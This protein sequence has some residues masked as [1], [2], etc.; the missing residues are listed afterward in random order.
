MK[1]MV[2]ICSNYLAQNAEYNKDKGPAFKLLIQ[3][4]RSRSSVVLFEKDKLRKTYSKAANELEEAKGLDNDHDEPN[5]SQEIHANL[6]QLVENVTPNEL[7]TDMAET[8]DISSKY[9]SQRAIDELERGPAFDV[10]IQ[11]LEMRGA[12]PFTPQFTSLGVK[13]AAAY[14]LK[15]APGLSS[16]TPD[17]TT[18]PIFVAAL[19]RAADAGTPKTLRKD[20]HDVIER[21]GNYLSAFV[22]DRDKAMQII[23]KA[24]KSNPTKELTK[25]RR[26]ALDYGTAATETEAAPIVVPFLAIKDIATEGKDNLNKD[27]ETVTPVELKTAMKSAVQDVSRY[28]SQPVALRSGAAGARYPLNFLSAVTKSLGARPLFKFKSYGQTYS[29]A[30][31]VLKYAGPLESDPKCEQLQYEIM[32]EMKRGVPTKLAPTVASG[33]DEVSVDAAKHLAKIGTE[34]GKAMDY[35]VGVMKQKGLSTLGQL[36]GYQQTYNDGARRIENAPTLV[37][38]KIDK[39]VYENVRGK[40]TKLITEKPSPEHEKL[41]PADAEKRQVL[42]DLMGRKGDQILGEDGLYKMTYTEASDDI[43]KAPVGV[44]TASDE[45][46]NKEMHR[47]ISSAIPDKKMHEI[48]KDPANEGA[49]YL[50]DVIHD[51]GEAIQVIHDEMKDRKGKDFL[52]IGKFK[53]THGEAAAM[54][55]EANKFGGQHPSPVIMDKVKERIDELPKAGASEGANRQM[56]DTTSIVSA[57]IA[58]VA[59]DECGLDAKALAA[60]DRKGKSASALNVADAEA[61]RLR[62][63]AEEAERR[64]REEE[65]IKKR[66]EEE[67]R[68]REEEEK[69]KS[70]EDEERKRREQDE[71]RRLEEERKR[72]GD[73]EEARRKRE[74]EERKRLEEEAKKSKEAD[75]KKDKRAG[76]PSRSSAADQDREREQAL[77]I[78][79]TQLRARDKEILYKQPHT[80][81]THSQAS[82]WIGMKP[83]M[84]V[85]KSVKESADTGRLHKKFERKLSL[86]VAKSTPA[87]MYDTMQD[88]IIE[89]SRILSEYFVSSNYK[90]LV[91]EALISEMQKRGNEILIEVD[92]AAETFFFSAQRLKKAKS[93]EVKEPCSQV[94]YHLNKRLDDMIRCRSMARKLTATMKDHVKDASDYLSEQVTKPDEQIEAYVSLLEEMEAAG[95]TLLIE[96]NIPKSYKDAAAYLRQLTSLE[97]QIGR[98]NSTL[99]ASIEGKLKTLMANV[100]ASGYSVP[101]MHGVIKDSTRLLVSYIMLQGEKTEALKIMIE[102]MEQ[103]GECVLLRHGNLRKSYVE[104]ANRLCGKNTDQLGVPSADPV[105]ARKIQIKLN[106]LMRDCTPPKYQPL[107]DDVIEDATMY[108]AVHFLQPHIIKVCKCMKN[109]FV[110]CELWC[111][112]ILRRVARPCCTCS[113]HIS[114][115]ALEDLA[116]GQR[117]RISPGSSR[118]FAPGLQISLTQCPARPTRSPRRGEKPTRQPCPASKPTEGCRQTTA[119]Y[120]LYSTEYNIRG[121]FDASPTRALLQT[122][123]NS[124]QTPSTPSSPSPS[125]LTSYSST[126]P[127]RS[128]FFNMHDKNQIVQR[129]NEPIYQT[130]R[131]QIV[132][133]T[134]T[135]SSFH[136]PP[137]S[138][139][140]SLADTVNTPFWQNPTAMYARYSRNTNRQ[141]PEN[142][143]SSKKRS[144]LRSGYSARTPIVS[145]DQ[146]SDWHAMM[147][148]LMWN[149]Q[150]WRDWIQENIDRARAFQR[151]RAESDSDVNENWAA[152]QRRVATEAL[153]W[154]QYN[155]FS[156]QLTLRLVL[157]YQDKQIVSPTRATVK[158]QAYME[159]QREMLDII[160]MFNR[161]TQWLT[162]VIKETDSLRED[163][164]SDGSLQETR[165]QY[166]KSKVEEY[167]DD[168]DKYNMHLKV[169]WEHKYRSLIADWL[170]AWEQSGP[171]WV[172]S[173]CGAVPSGAVA[174][175]VFDGEVVWVARTTHKCNVLPAALHPSKHCCIVYAD[176]AV[177]H[178]TKYQVSSACYCLNT[179]LYTDK[180]CQI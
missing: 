52:T 121:G 67:R 178:Y 169:C 61:E 81:L 55:S 17:E 36:Q 78:L 161:W 174:A 88:V 120:L 85:D 46:K 47:R 26:Y 106:N 27:V 49:A 179:N 143:A 29:D 79:H 136:T 138:N 150:A 84:K 8:V 113:R 125:G 130:T 172:V 10:L 148:S 66:E 134:S 168:W 108:L 164:H 140:A 147:V 60:L 94:A 53:K 63:E 14:E 153:Q 89:S 13:Y 144:R 124:L 142:E 87:N 110:Q 32:S 15:T 50:T 73:E 62:L 115:Q 44:V 163:P 93:M 51:R 128:H 23:L 30:A 97:D 159:C 127:L 119:S 68:K 156:R 76:K 170:P 69:K 145:T 70:G 109:V 77:S 151:P 80:E 155:T 176:G 162:L 165:W 48:L 34:K 20:M 116:P 122:P 41:L 6:T 177:H 98:A 133:D 166:F 56:D 16:V 42:A 21:C 95:D 99:Q 28:L 58:G 135:S 114:A 111:D 101:V 82:H 149:V 37:N 154:R 100:T 118:A 117:L 1:D 137:T 103:T 43:M 157:R 18:A 39:G 57:Y 2:E 75:E 35:L 31:D 64:K 104:G 4:M 139:L 45:A 123:S 86:L 72:K 105:V 131:K 90:A 102:K 171:V 91:Q 40:L 33:L 132:S 160:D 19:H 180:H 126:S 22:R 7:K 173:A 11:E 65:D 141:P 83:P 3:T 9:L 38:E 112:E 24:M 92:G 152:F 12:D 5:L 96:G 25:R 175:G 59:T 74:E 158:T 129:E 167:A 146:M 71:M 54:I 107:I